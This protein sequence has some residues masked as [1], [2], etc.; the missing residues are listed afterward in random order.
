MTGNQPLVSGENWHRLSRNA[1]LTF[2]FYCLVALPALFAN[3]GVASIAVF[4][5]VVLCSILIVL[6]V[7]DIEWYLL[8]D[9][10]TL[11]LLVIGLALGALESWEVA[12]A[13]LA[14]AVA[15]YATLYL[16]AVA[17]ERFRGYSGLGLGD[18]KL[19]AAAGAWL[20]AAALPSV[21]LVAAASALVFVA[22]MRLRGVLVTRTTVLPFGPFLAFGTWLI[23]LYG[24]F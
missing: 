9:I 21:V 23:W 3:F 19:L 6:T 10:L 2:V 7:V 16:V 8:P 24:T 17:Y 15:G 4:S 22:A 12:A 18:A 13:R 14:A 20:G 5:A 1:A 11:P